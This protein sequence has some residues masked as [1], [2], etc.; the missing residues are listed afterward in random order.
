M[1][2]TYS[3]IAAD[4]PQWRCDAQHS[5]FSPAPLASEMKLLW[6]RSFSARQQAWPSPLNQYLMQFDRQFEP[7]VMDDVMLLAFND[8]DKVIGIDVESGKTL[9]SFFTGGPVRLAPALDKGRAYISCDD[10]FLYCLKISDGSLLWKFD[11]APDRRHVLGNR[12][13]I[14]MWPIRGG[15]VVEDGRVYFS[16]GIWPFMGVFLYCLDAESGKLVWIN[17]YDCI[18]YRNQP[19]MSKAFAGIAPQGVTAIKGDYL[20]APGGRSVPGVYDAGSG[21]ERYYFFAEYSKNFGGDFVAVGDKFHFVRARDRKGKPVYQAFDNKS[22]NFIKNNLKK[23]VP[24]IYGN[25]VF[26][27]P[28]DLKAEDAIIAGQTAYVGGKGFIAA[29]DTEKSSVLWRK[30]VK[31]TVVRLLAASDCLFAVTLEGNLLCFCS[32]ESD[33]MEFELALPV[34]VLHAHDDSLAVVEKLKAAASLA[35]GYALVWG[36]GDGHLLETLAANSDY[37]VIAVDASSEKVSAMR[38]KLDMTNQY[39]DK[40]SIQHAP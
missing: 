27:A 34:A 2:I 35:C 4:W 21:K 9:W 26:S 25:S 3:S 13:V 23:S 31:G 38:R 6:K 40:I 14:S 11:A 16:A 29:L 39:G 22:G 1:L 12:R 10:G 7:V 37:S 33:K 24:V 5:G 20:F 18:S 28:S 32:A 8:A 30:E 19:H 15:A 17:D 36:I